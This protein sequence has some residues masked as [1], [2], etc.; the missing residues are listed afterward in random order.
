[1]SD[2]ITQIVHRDPVHI[3]IAEIDRLAMQPQN[4]TTLKSIL[5]AETKVKNRQEIIRTLKY[6]LNQLTK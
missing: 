2:I 1:M 6:H 5:I 3:A 4:T